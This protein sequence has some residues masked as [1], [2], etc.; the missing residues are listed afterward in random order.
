MSDV[1]HWQVGYPLIATTVRRLLTGTAANI[2]VP[3]TDTPPATGK[4]EQLFTVGRV[5]DVVYNSMSTEIVVSC[6]PNKA[7]LS[8]VFPARGRRCQ[9]QGRG[10]GR[11]APASGKF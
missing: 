5:I 2:L 9:D 4:T 8:R 11:G 1:G 7:L 6:M 10:L 3:M